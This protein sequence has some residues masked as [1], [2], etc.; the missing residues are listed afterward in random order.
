MKSRRFDI[1]PKTGYKWVN[2]FKAEGMSGLA[3]RSR[4]RHTQAHR[5]PDDVIQLILDYK[6]RYP[7][8]GPATIHSNLHRDYP[9]ETWPAAMMV[10]R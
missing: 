4:A 8:W 6:H 3:D 9:G 1:S 10:P 2:R 7:D 5:T